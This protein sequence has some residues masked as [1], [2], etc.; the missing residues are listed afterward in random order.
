MSHLSRSFPHHRLDAYRVALELAGLAKDLADSV[1]RGYRSI[2]DQLLR[3]A[4][5]TVL[6]IGE[7]ASRYGPGL[8]RQRYREALGECGE[9]AAA[10][11]LLVHLRLADTRQVDEALGLAM[12]V[13]AMLT[14]LARRF[15]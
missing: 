9:V 14:G 8:K 5:S 3:A 6:L 12:R 2:S 13:Q 7:G 1:P 15:S 4:T 11:E 10:L